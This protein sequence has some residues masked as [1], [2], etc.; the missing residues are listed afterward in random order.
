MGNL[1]TTF[2]PKDH[3]EL[4]LRFFLASGL[5]RNMVSSNFSENEGFSTMGLPCMQCNESFS[6]RHAFESA[7]YDEGVYYF[8][9]I[10]CKDKWLSVNAPEIELENLQQPSI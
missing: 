9:S 7:V 5:H 2:I 4:A 10:E 1:N 3:A 8:C 6:T